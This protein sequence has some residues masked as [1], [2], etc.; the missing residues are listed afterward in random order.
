MCICLLNCFRNSPRPE[1][2]LDMFD[3]DMKLKL[4]NSQPSLSATLE[5]GVELN[6][7]QAV[8]EFKTSERTLNAICHV[9]IRGITY[10]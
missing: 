6:S 2:T 10:L 4:S 3:I 9:M 8:F 1:N 5:S 7:N